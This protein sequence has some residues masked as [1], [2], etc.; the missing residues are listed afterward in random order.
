[1]KDKTGYSRLRDPGKNKGTAFTPEERKKFGLEGQL[2]EQ[3][4]AEDF[5][6]V[7]IYPRVNDI[8]RVSENV[9]EKIAEQI[10]NSGLAGVKRPKDIRAFIKSKMYEPVY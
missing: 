1:M 10:F 2:P 6:S 9:A 4:T 7:L 3:V 8:L 5:E